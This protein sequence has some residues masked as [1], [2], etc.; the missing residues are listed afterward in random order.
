MDAGV[1]TDGEGDARCSG[2]EGPATDAG[3]SFG[4]PDWPVEQPASAS[5]MTRKYTARRDIT[6]AL[7]RDE[8]SAL[9]LLVAIVILSMFFQPSDALRD[10]TSIGY[11]RQRERIVGA[12]TVVIR[13][14][15]ACSY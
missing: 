15:P 5:P 2:D 11:G 14:K 7:R 4:D 3:D 9:R 8:R 13:A 1:A 12:E 10:V 6:P